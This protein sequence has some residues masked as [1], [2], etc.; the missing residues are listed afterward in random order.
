VT[1]SRLG[2]ALLFALVTIA[3]P[4][5]G[6]ATT[7]DDE[8][9]AS[10]S[11]TKLDV[12]RDPAARAR[13]LG[14]RLAAARA[15]RPT[16]AQ[17][18]IG[19]AVVDLATHTALAVH[20]GERGLNIASNA[21]VLTSA[22][23]LAGL[24]AGFRWR[25]A[26]LVTAT[27]DRAGVVRGD[28]FIRG[29]GDPT[30]TADHLDH[31]A[32]EVAARGIHEVTGQLVVDATYFD[33]ATEPP[34]FDEQPQEQSYFRAP[35]ASFA[36]DHS[37]FTVVVAGEATGPARVTVAP[38]APEYLRL[39]RSEVS[40]AITGSTRLRLEATHKPDAIELDLT[41]VI[42]GGGGTWDLRRR[43][44]DPA[45]FAAEVFRRALADRGV[46]LR[47]K[48]IA[49]AA[50]PATARAIALHDSAPLGDVLRAMN[51]HSDNNIAETV[52]KTLGAERKTTPGPAT[53]ADGLAEVSAQLGK[54][55][56]QGKVVFENG[57]GLFAS[58]AV[59]A[60]QLV[61]VLVAA[62]ADYRIGPDLVASLPV[63][64]RDGTLA[65]RWRG[66]LAE[67]R[68]RAKTGTLDKVSSLAGYVGVD[69]GHLLAFAIIANDVPSGQRGVVRAMADDMVDSLVAYLDA[70]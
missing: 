16:L 23:A 32:L 8:D 26:V 46:K 54:L 12:P 50:A 29:R 52:L 61:A 4:G 57:S 60:S 56:V 24:G 59:S 31:L 64:G 69:G 7:D 43:V 11:G 28:L 37:A 49:F 55:G 47:G 10:G 14:E 17:A 42:R 2:G 67:G 33:S 62:H 5:S 68:V 35:V 30:L 6:S 34:H 38:R 20:D 21:K 3:Q 51:K 19:Y 58:T 9:A 40:S 18:R 27:P 15:S 1:S 36:V 48:A 25:T 66:R 22:A 39:V 41:G 44:A 53:W 63:G 70:R 65:R 45:R 13:W